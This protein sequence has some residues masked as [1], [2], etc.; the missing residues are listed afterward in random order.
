MSREFP[1]VDN[2]TEDFWCGN[3]QHWTKIRNKMIQDG[4]I[5]CSFY[6]SELALPGE[7]TFKT[8]G[9]EFSWELSS[10]V[11]YH[12]QTNGLSCLA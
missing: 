10:I 5:N 4:F 8:S 6:E 3:E 12:V 1:L 2:E 9:A 11:V 7:F